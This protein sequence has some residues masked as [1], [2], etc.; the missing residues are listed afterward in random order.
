MKGMKLIRRIS[1]FIMISGMMLGVGG[2]TALKAEQFFYPNR[3]RTGET[4]RSAAEEKPA[5]E[6]AEQ[7]IEAAAESIPVVNA[8]TTYLVEEV[9]LTDGTIRETEESVP[10]R[11]TV[12]PEKAPARLSR[13]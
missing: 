11:T 3:Y 12:S 6:P 4:A 8:D 10:V 7:V 5:E 2:Y 9:D 13:T 1:L